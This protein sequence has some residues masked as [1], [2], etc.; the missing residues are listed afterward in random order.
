MN[1]IGYPI[2]IYFKQLIVNIQ[3]Q[4]LKGAGFGVADFQWILHHYIKN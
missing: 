3:R 2:L 1:F 4:N